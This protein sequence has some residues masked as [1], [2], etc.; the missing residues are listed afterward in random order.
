MASRVEDSDVH[1]WSLKKLKP[2]I[3]V[4]R[5]QIPMAMTMRSKPTVVLNVTSCSL[6]EVY[7]MCCIQST[8]F[9]IQDDCRLLT[10]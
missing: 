9:D 10:L 3:A 1:N 8:W 5:F 4:L 2:A 7:L 6:V